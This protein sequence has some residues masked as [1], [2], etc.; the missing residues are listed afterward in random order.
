MENLKN[1]QLIGL[2]M[3]RIFIG[4]LFLHEGL[5]KL[6]N[7]YWSAAGF[8]NDS[9]WIFSSIFNWMAGN[10]MILNVVNMI[11]IWGL[12]LIGCGLIAGCFTQTA[13]LA[14]ISLLLLYYLSNPP[15]FGYIYSFPQ[16]G[17]YLIVNKTL[18][19][20]AALFV[21]YLFPT[22]HRIGV[23]RIIKRKVKQ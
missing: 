20:M 3:L 9:Q 2:V 7:P 1:K 15:L 17:N 13:T 18:I 10:P 11:N 8:L 19:E 4:W 6:A 22:G 5:V 23:D 14:G 16:E 12:I 21:L